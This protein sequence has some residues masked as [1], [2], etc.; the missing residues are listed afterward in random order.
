M[1]VV[2]KYVKLPDSDNK[3]KEI[4]G[5]DSILKPFKVN[6]YLIQDIIEIGSVASGQDRSKIRESSLKENLKFS[7][8]LV[9]SQE[10]KDTE[11]TASEAAT[12]RT[13]SKKNLVESETAL[14]TSSLDLN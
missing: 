5:L 6:I 4:I 2:S 11:S 1:V 3:R 9:A 12:P 13:L 10:D 8:T 7:K 14:K